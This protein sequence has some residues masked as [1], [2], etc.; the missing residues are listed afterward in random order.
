ML[1]LGAEGIP[2]MVNTTC[3]E[4]SGP[5]V[6]VAVMMCG[7]GGK[8]ESSHVAVPEGRLPCGYRCSI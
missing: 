7:F 2:L 5:S 4:S 3:V 8:E 6:S 1:I